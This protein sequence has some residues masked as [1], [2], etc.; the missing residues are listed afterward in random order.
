MRA[1]RLPGVPP[2][3]TL[4]EAIE[5]TRIHSVAGLLRPGQAL[6]P[7]RPFRAPHHSISDAGLIGGGTGPRPGGGL[8]APNGGLFLDELAE[9]RRNVLERLRQPVGEGTLSITPGSAGLA[10]PGP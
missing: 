1:R 4:D 10:Y 8:L 5:S 6:L 9:Y 3:M 7:V 2:P